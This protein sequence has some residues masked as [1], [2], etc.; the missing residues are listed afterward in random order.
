MIS[1]NNQYDQYGFTDSFLNALVPTGAPAL[2]AGNFSDSFNLNHVYENKIPTQSLVNNGSTPPVGGGWFDGWGD[3]EFW[4]GNSKTGAKG[5]AMPMLAAVGGLMNGWLGFEQ[6]NLAKDQL[7]ENKHQFALNFNNQASLAN[8]NLRDR[9]QA[10][11][12]AGSNA[13]SVDSY[14]KENAVR[15]A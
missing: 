4:L 1:D 3:S 10:R 7:K 6:L 12:G 9:Q 11:I 5:A 14:M 13:Q 15:Y 8:T 2:N